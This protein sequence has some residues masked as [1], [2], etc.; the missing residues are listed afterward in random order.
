MRG[1]LGLV[2]SL[3]LVGVLPAVAT[4]SEVALGRDR[5][6][7]GCSSCHQVTRTQKQPAPVSDPD[8]MTLV[9]A[10][11]FAQISRKYQGND[12]ALRAFITAPDHPMKEQQF[13]QSDL[14]AIVAYIH[15]AR[16][17]W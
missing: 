5:A 14:T 16:K 7:E 6:I 1:I 12:R 2:A 10:P 3:L 4:P 13:L 11:N 9:Q 17:N 15:S 8:Q